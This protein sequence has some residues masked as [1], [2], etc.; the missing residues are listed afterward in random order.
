MANSET[1]PVLMTAPAPLIFAA[2]SGAASGGL[3][4]GYFTSL[5]TGT[6]SAFVLPAPTQGAMIGVE[7]A[8]TATAGRSLITDAAGTKIG[9][10]NRTCTL[11]MGDSIILVGVSST[12]W[13][14]LHAGGVFSA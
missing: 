5:G 9:T 7:H 4:I 10:T 12:R 11:A 14:V 2:T 13:A 1:E 3:T 6:G 8:G